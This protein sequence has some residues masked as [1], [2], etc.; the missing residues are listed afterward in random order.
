MTEKKANEKFSQIILEFKM[1]LLNTFPEL[2]SALKISDDEIFAHC[3]E[4]YPKIFF[5]LLYENM[6]LFKEPMFLLPNI[7]FTILMN[8]NVT[9]KTK[10]TI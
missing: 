2:E 3:S 5:E 9:E 6:T 10:K 1:D 7:D 8:E 4:V